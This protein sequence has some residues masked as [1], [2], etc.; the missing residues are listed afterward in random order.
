MRRITNAP[1]VVILIFLVPALF[2]FVFLMWQRA[3]K[4]SM[5]M[6]ECLADG[7]KRYQCVSMLRR[8]SG[9]ILVV[10]R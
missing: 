9:P 10:P 5:L 6:D 4:D 3:A 2:C 7:N 1:E 8:N